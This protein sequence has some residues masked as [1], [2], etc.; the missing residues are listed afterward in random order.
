METRMSGNYIKESLKRRIK[1][2]LSLR[3]SP[4]VTF[5]ILRSVRRLL[6]TARV[7]PSSPVLVTPMKEVLSSSET[8]VLTRVTRGNIPEDVILHSHC[9]E[10]LK[11]YKNNL[12]LEN[13]CSSRDYEI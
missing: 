12:S 7:F 8:S 11:S 3:E 10:N 1:N 5:Y 9:R 13:E 6:V 2:C 4:V